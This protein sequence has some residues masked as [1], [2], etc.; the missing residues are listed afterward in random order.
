MRK[1]TSDLKSRDPQELEYAISR[2]SHSMNGKSKKKIVYNREETLD[3]WARLDL[4]DK[5]YLAYRQVSRELEGKLSPG[6]EAAREMKK[7]TRP[8]QIHYEEDWVQ[9]PLKEQIKHCAERTLLFLS[10]K[11]VLPTLSSFDKKNLSISAKVG[12]DGQSDQTEFQTAATLVDGVVDKSVY[13]ICFVLLEIRAGNK[14][15]WTN[16]EPNSPNGTRHLSYS[17]RKETNEF[18]QQTFAA[19]TAEIESLPNIT[20]EVNGEEFT[21]KPEPSKIYCTMND[22]KTCSAVVSKLLGGSQISS[23]KCHVCLQNQA[24]FSKPEIWETNSSLNEEFLDLGMCVLHCWIRSMEYIFNSACRIPSLRRGEKVSM[25]SVP[26]I[27]EKHRLQEIFKKELLIKIFFVNKGAGTT[28]T[29]NMARKF[30]N[31]ERTAVILNIDPEIISLFRDLNR[32]LNNPN[33]RPNPE[34]YELKARKLFHHLTTGDFKHI[35]LSPTV[36]RMVTH[37]TSFIRHFKD[38]PIGALSES[39]IESKNKLNRTSRVGHARMFSFSKNTQDA[40]NHMLLCSDY[41][42]FNKHLARSK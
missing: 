41:Y 16:S 26:F 18:I 42:L 14:T 8:N 2:Q 7:I 17:F 37:G 23:L 27:A 28:N 38:I 29:G 15:I 21:I 19:L 12:G 32:S 4:T 30:F 3:L 25:T 40:F 24:A 34:I 20:F 9:C 39:A 36:H 5:K 10:D 11:E 1:R 13:S 6:R 22:G 35:P 31:S 33:I